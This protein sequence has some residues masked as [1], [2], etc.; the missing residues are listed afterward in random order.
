MAF[1][2]WAR[3]E[4]AVGFG[5]VL[6]AIQIYGD[7]NV[8]LPPG[9]PFFR[10]SDA[11]ECRRVLQA[12]GFANPQVQTVPQVWRLSTPDALCEIMHSS[13]VRTAALLRAQAPAALTAIRA[14][15]REAALAYQQGSMIELPMPAVAAAAAK[16]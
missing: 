9:P 10:F 14:A 16:P 13:S 5:I 4:E 15:I 12:A 8:P 2:V 3:P 1:T 7:M 11:D 6:R